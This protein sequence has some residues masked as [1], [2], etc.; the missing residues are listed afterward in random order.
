MEIT[1][2]EEKISHFT[3]H[4]RKNADHESR[5]YPLFLD[6]YLV[7]HGLKPGSGEHFQEGHACA[8]LKPAFETST[9]PYYKVRD[10]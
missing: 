1:I 4:E 3:F 5:K 7:L 8:I 10:R 6:S 2:H 9:V